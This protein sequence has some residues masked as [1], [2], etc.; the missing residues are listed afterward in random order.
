MLSTRSRLLI[1]AIIIPAALSAQK[2][3]KAGHEYWNITYRG[4]DSRI[5]G[6]DLVGKLFLTDSTVRLYFN[7]DKYDAPDFEIPIRSITNFTGT[8]NRVGA[9]LTNWASGDETIS[10]AY[11]HD[12]DAEAPV[13]KTP[14]SESAQILARIRYRMRKLGVQ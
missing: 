8:N 1:G 3:D 7:S 14:G 13:F 9:S 4:G 11:D 10:L 6:S 2:Q 5:G 12:K